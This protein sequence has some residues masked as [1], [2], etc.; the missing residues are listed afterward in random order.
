MFCQEILTTGQSLIRSALV[1]VLGL[2]VGTL[3]G[4]HETRSRTVTKAHKSAEP[5]AEAARTNTSGAAPKESSG[6]SLS[7]PTAS[8]IRSVKVTKDYQRGGLVLATIE[9]DGQAKYTYFTLPSPYRLVVD[10]HN[11]ASEVP[12]VIQI[13]MAEVK[14]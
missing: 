13:G 14:R 4:T 11:V 9:L 7:T 12:S 5:G 8:S 1:C 6:K 3:A 10:V 2:S